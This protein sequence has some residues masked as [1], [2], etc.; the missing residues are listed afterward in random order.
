MTSVHKKDTPVDNVEHSKAI[1]AF[2]EEI[3][4]ASEERNVEQRRSAIEA[5]AARL[6]GEIAR[7]PTVPLFFLLGYALYFHPDRLTSPAIQE[8]L[9]SALQSALDLDPGYARAHMYL[10]HQAWDLGRYAEAKSHF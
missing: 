5:I 7:S 8:R 2:W 3:E 1:E 4:R 6:A 10:G 9:K